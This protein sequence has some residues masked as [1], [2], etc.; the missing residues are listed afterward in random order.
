VV[1]LSAQ[2]AFKQLANKLLQIDS[3]AGLPRS[4]RPRRSSAMG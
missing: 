2:Q 1:G 4:R 3:Q